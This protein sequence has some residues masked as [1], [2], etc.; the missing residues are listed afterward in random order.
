VAQNDAVTDRGAE[1][2]DVRGVLGHGGMGVVHRGFD[3]RL[4]REVALKTLRQATGRDLFRFKREFRALADIVH[5]NLVVLHELHTAGDEWFF[6]ME[7][8]EG[9]G[10]LDWVRFE[11]S[12]D[13]PTAE[14]TID[15]RVSALRQGAVGPTPA[16]PPRGAV[17]LP[18]LVDALGQLV[19]GVL[20]L[21]VSGK[22]HRDL[23]PSNVLV[24]PDGRVVL[25]DFGLVASV[26]PSH[27]DQTHE[28]AAVGTP[29]YM[30]PEQAAD[31]PLDEACDWYAVGV[32]LYEALT[33][34]RPFQG[35]ADVVMRRKQVELPPAPAAIDPRVRP[36][37]DALCMRLLA[38]AP[39]DRPSG[40]AILSALGRGPSRSTL[41]LERAQASG[42]FVGREPEMAALRAAFADAGGRGVAVFVRGD[43]GMGKSQL[44]RRFVDEL[45]GRAQ[46]LEGRCYE[47][48]AVP[49]KTLDTVIDALTGA[50]MRLPEARLE[51]VLPRDIA[52]LAR[53]FP[54]LRRVELVSARAIGTTLP[55]DPQEIRRR[56][57]AA[58]RDL[59]RGLGDLA[60]VVIAI[61]DLQWGDADSA[62][63]L[64]ELIHHP[65]PVPLLLVLIHRLEDDAGVVAKVQVA[66]PGIPAGDTRC[67]DVGPLAPGE[68]RQ[69]VQALGGGSDLSAEVLVREGG[70]H[71]LFLAELARGSGAAS[72]LEELIARRIDLLPA[73]AAALLRTAAVAAR[74]VP[75]DQAARAAGLASIGSELALLRAERLVRVRH[76]LE[77]DVAMVE[78][79]HDRI[80]AAAVAS[81]S[82]AEQRAVHGA[83]ARTFEEAAGRGDLEG[84]VVHW[85]AAGEP[86]RAATFAVRAAQHAEE[87]LAFHRAAEL[88]AIARAHGSGR[89]DQQRDLLR[90]RALALANAGALDAAADAFGEAA[91]GAGPDEALDLERLRMEQLVRRGRMKEGIALAAGLLA[92]VGVRLPLQGGSVLRAAM[93]ERVRLRLRGI[94]YRERAAAAVPPALRQTVDLLYSTAGGLAFMEPVAGKALQ[95][96]FLRLALDAGESRRLILA[97]G[98]EIGYL[99]TSGVSAMPRVEAMVS[100]LG[101]VVAR[102][103]QPGLVGFATCCEGLAAFMFGRWRDSRRCMDSGLKALRDHGVGLRWEATVGELYL[104]SAL[105]YLGETRELARLVPLLLRDAVERGDV[106]AQHGLRAWRSNVAWLVMGRPDE[107]R[108]HAAAVARERR[109]GEGFHLQHYFEML[110]QA[111]IDLYEGAPGAAWQRIEAAWKPL[112]RSY[113]LRIQSVRTE[114][115]YLR[116]RVA[117]ATGDPGRLAVAR[118]AARSL[119]REGA[120]WARALAL[121]V[122]ALIEVA[123]GDREAALDRL[124]K[125]E[126]ACAAAD[127][128]LY[129]SA[130]RLRRGQLHAGAAGAA[131]AA[132]AV[133]A[134][135][136]QAI[137]DPE[138]MA[139]TVCP[140]PAGRLLT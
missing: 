80:R 1:R 48:E 95:F 121:V 69:L 76:R 5:P 111:Q 17:D 12:A 118:R 73:A 6:S 52:A 71:P 33:G 129:A 39:G 125:A 46:I 130:L 66:R 18:R 27:V 134:M 2:F 113:L 64:A 128:A 89:P 65:E 122:R 105:Y 93:I 81:L 94:R 132:E 50:L 4:G 83:L 127:M 101:K 92:R 36:D 74:P 3:R 90:R 107:A 126:R 19:D 140:W 31:R 40:R 115:T 56:A 131:W 88:Y 11:P 123:T 96:R 112:T 77:S 42:P 137:A 68:A 23:K 109:V 55:P 57:F 25:L 16:P 26:D 124:E 139:R 15:E 116:A 41:E 78:P 87:A 54:V 114:A 60:P 29:A 47:R 75:A 82:A 7:L 43:S 117:L 62:A 28:H 37:L 138:A 70:G 106:Y 104:T 21:H 34:R 59:L 53:L 135:R 79:Y 14:V 51:A 110:T 35:T 108:A 119:E 103:P 120:P 61:D 85:L 136:E 91:I 20:A 22:L 99:G 63:F 84:V 58:L 102:D 97:L 13:E 67:I 44:V 72:S 98:M 100:L 10:F 86:A 49:Y 24:T 32:M 8:V 9:V 133:A 30:A 38:L 45:A